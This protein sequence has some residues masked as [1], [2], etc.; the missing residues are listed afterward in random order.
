MYCPASRLLLD[1]ERKKSRLLSDIFGDDPQAENG[2]A[3]IVGNVHAPLGSQTK[4]AAQVTQ[5]LA[6]R[7]GC[8]LPGSV[9]M[10]QVQFALREALSVVSY[11]EKEE[12]HGGV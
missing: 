11:L 3:G 7:D 10:R 6:G 4:P 8:L 1:R 9:P 12:G 2:L 5:H